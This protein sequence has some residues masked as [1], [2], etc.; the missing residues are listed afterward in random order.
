MPTASEKTGRIFFLDV[1]RTVAIIF[2][3]L[4]HYLCAWQLVTIKTVTVKFGF[5]GALGV[6]LFLILSGASLCT[7]TQKAFSIVTF[8]KKRFLSIL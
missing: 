2:I 8:Y 5:L 6:S 3:I 7:S 4:Y 1:I